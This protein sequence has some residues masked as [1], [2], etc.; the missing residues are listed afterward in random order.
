VSA[1]LS[2]EEDKFSRRFHCQKS[3]LS[4]ESASVPIAHTHFD[5]LDFEIEDLGFYLTKISCAVILI[6][7]QVKRFPSLTLDFLAEDV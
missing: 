7:F 4:L 5:S 6:T 1:F 2:L 3:L